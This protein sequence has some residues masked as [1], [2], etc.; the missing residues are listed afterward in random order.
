MSV[1]YES[2]QTLHARASIL[3]HQGILTSSTVYDSTIISAYSFDRSSYFAKV[4]TTAMTDPLVLSLPKIGSI[5]SMHI[6]VYSGESGSELHLA[7]YADDRVN[8]GSLGAEKVY[9]GNGGIQFILLIG[10]KN[11]WHAS[12]QSV[13][14][15]SITAGSGCTVTGSYPD[16]TISVP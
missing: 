5:S 15:V 10:T 12:I 11:V 7:P 8:G 16:F 4:V 9:S 6:L 1:S 2:L 13:A 3:P 14:P